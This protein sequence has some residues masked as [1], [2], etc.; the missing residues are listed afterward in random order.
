MKKYY[1]EILIYIKM[2]QSVYKY[3]IYCNTE[4]DY[5]YSW[6]NTE[7]TTCPNDTAHSIDTNSIAIIETISTQTI[8][9]EENSDGYFET[10]HVVMN[11]PTGSPGDI[12]TYDV[13]W[14]MDI[15]LW[16]T[17]ITPT[18]DMIGDSISVL[19]APET[20]VG[21]LTASASIGQTTISVNSTVLGNVSRG[22][23]ITLYDGV[24]KN[25]CGRCTEVNTTNSTISFQTAI[26]NNFSA[27]TAVKISIYVLNNINITDTTTID[28]G[29]KGFKGKGVPSGLI[30]R[31]YYTNNSGTSKIV[32]WRPE[33]YSVG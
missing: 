13:T 5:V 33:Y 16:R 9:A 17:F 20:T 25:V 24:N 8:K 6:G 27:G 10:T 29:T 26:T 1:K 2:S 21:V 4:A 23:L 22:F 28:I 19:A 30:M 11:I 7:P 12:T 32:R 31:V 14:P 18:S 15:I 3:R